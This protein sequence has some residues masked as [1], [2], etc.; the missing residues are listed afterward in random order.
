MKSSLPGS[1]PRPTAGASSKLIRLIVSLCVVAAFIYFSRERA[2]QVDPAAEQTPAAQTGDPEVVVLPAK[3]LTTKSADLPAES[4]VD[5]APSQ[6]AVKTLI[7][8]VVIR[9]QDGSVI[10]RGNIDLS[11]TLARI[12]RRDYGSHVNDGSVFQNREKRLPKQPS[13]YYHE[14]VHPTPKQ[15]GPGP[16]RIVTGEQGELYYTPDHYETFERLDQPAGKK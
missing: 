16:Q 12:E 6:P 11:E 8:N 9:N 2:K 5:R 3:K 7:K 14:W 13:G 1:Q 4:T 10:Y 15:R